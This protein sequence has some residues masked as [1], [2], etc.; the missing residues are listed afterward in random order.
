MGRDSRHTTTD[1]IIVFARQGIAMTTIARAMAISPSVV[2]NVCRRANDHGELQMIPAMTPDDTRHSLLSELT[3]LRAQLDDAQY[4]LREMHEAARFESDSFHGV[5]GL[6]KSEAKIVSAIVRHGTISKSG[7]YFALYGNADDAPEPKVIDVLMCKIRKKLGLHG[8]SVVTHWGSGFG[9]SD[10][11]IAA[12][13][14]L[15]ANASPSFV[16]EMAA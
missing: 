1:V 4:T 7:L 15:R 16:P 5:A 3:N 10:V 8:I 6:S 14:E 9:M 11:D 13:R 12:V 2:E